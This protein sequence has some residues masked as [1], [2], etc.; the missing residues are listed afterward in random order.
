MR[1]HLLPH[2]TSFIDLFVESSRNAVA[3]A[4]LLQDLVHDYT[5]I[6]EKTAKITE[7]EHAGDAITH[8]II[9]QLHRSFVT[10]FDREDIAALAGSLD[11][12]TDL[13]E[14]AADT[15]VVYKVDKPSEVATK[16]ADTIVLTAM[17]V[18][19]AVMRLQQKSELKKILE[20]CVEINRLENM[21]DDEFRAAKAELFEI[22]HDYG[23]VFKWHEI[24]QLMEEATDR[25][26]DVSDI[27][28]GIV[29]KNA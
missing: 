23:Y 4:R 20:I 1:W 9:A 7:L 17:Q 15:M 21:A 29:L 24:Y 3:A 28:E 14:A 10:P 22:E 26:E 8:R 5:N 27:L 13:I 25:C 19:V 12:V 11:D 18:E 6:A 2:K 16:L